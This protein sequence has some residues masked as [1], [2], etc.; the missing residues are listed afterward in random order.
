MKLTEVTLYTMKMRMKT[1]FVTSFGTIQDKTV[2][3]IKATEETGVVG[4]GEGV[5]FD[6]P[7]YTEETAKTTLHMLKDF[8]IPIVLHKEITHPDEVNRLFQP[9]RR[10]MMAKSAIEGAI[11]DIYA[12]LTNQ[13]LAAAIGGT[14]DKIEIGISIGLQPTSEQ[15][16]QV[17]EKRLNEGYKRIKIKIKPGK[18]IELVR[19]IR[20]RFGTIPLMAD[21]NSAYTMGDLPLLK[22]LDKYELM[23]IEQPLA[24]DDLVEHAMLQKTLATPICLDES[25][26]S[27]AD[28]KRAVMLGSCKV[29]NLKIARVGGI[30][31]AKK[32]HDYCVEQGI[33]LWCGGMLEAGIGRAHAVAISSLSGFTMPGDT[34]G[35]SHYWYEDIIE[36]EVVVENGFIQVPK[37]TGLGY[38]V[39]QS[40]IEQS[41][42][43]KIV[44]S[45]RLGFI[46]T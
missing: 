27:L 39:K 1:P 25:I 33:N 44:L 18:D 46:N 8:L 38:K 17:I 11:W 36:P 21:A 5:A 13:T 45:K 43:Q 15:L 16:F 22:E 7:S 6:H 23:M 32:I 26:T 40:F 37:K 28:V 34:A 12:Q 4:W 41:A 20:E 35:S 9:I 2:I 42:D 29:V 19:A 10:N 24:Y 30:T 14:R 3:I 31:E